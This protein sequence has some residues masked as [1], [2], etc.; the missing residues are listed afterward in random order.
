[1]SVTIPP[2]FDRTPTSGPGL[3]NKTRAALDLVERDLGYQLTIVQPSYNS[4]VGASGGTHAGGGVIDLAPY[5]HRRKVKALRDRGFAA[6]YRGRRPGLW[7]PHIH[8]VLIR[9]GRLSPQA[10]DQ[11]GDY[12]AGRNG[13]ADHAPDPNPYR[14]APP[15]VFDYRAAAFDVVRR[16]RI[17]GL[18]ARRKALLDRIS[19]TRARIVYRK[20][21]I[22]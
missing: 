1:M 3:D 12:L 4:S 14:P 18:K 5:D 6:W 21:V 22:R 2:P 13:L 19:A 15:V 20:R 11:V 7:G 16:D 8:A 9:H 17:K 10:A